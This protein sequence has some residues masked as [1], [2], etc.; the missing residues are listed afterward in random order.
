MTYEIISGWIDR[1][2]GHAIN[3]K[4]TITE[5]NSA[6]V[7]DSNFELN[8]LINPITMVQVPYE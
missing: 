8:I 7:Y 6:V 2:N 3:L 4:Q 1:R 5:L